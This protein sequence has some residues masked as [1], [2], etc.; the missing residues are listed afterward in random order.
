MFALALAVVTVALM[1]PS[2]IIA[3]PEPGRLQAWLVGVYEFGGRR[4]WRRGRRVSRQALRRA[5][6]GGSGP[7]G[8]AAASAPREDARVRAI[9]EHEEPYDNGQDQ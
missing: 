3:L 5:G 4:S 9:R 2:V 1:F 7:P 8:R 6:P